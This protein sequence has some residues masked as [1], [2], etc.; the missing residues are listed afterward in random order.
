MQKS[1]SQ[2][3]FDLMVPSDS[4][5]HPDSHPALPTPPPNTVWAVLSGSISLNA[6]AKLLGSQHNT[7]VG[8]LTPPVGSSNKE[9][10][11]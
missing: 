9:P 6:G 10:K 8:K 3:A 11:E 5:S 1:R 4:D 7:M 2:A